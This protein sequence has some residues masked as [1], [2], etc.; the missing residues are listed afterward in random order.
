MSQSIRAY[1]IKW[2]NGW[3]DRSI[4]SDLKCIQVQNISRAASTAKRRDDHRK[5]YSFWMR[6]MPLSPTA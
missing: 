5:L 3:Q 2:G 1:E 6:S 4:T